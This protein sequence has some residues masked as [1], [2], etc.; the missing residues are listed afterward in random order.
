MICE[1]L[2]I[3]VTLKFCQHSSYGAGNFKMLLVLHFYPTWSKL[4]DKYDS[5]KVI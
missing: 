5:H 3:Y 4:Y 2:K 1:N